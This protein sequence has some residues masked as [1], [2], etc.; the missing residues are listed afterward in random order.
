MSR[1]WIF[2]ANPDRYE[3][4]GAL[5]ELDEIWWRVP[6]YTDEIHIGDRVVVWR[7]G[8]DSGV[9]GLGRVLSEPAERE[10]P[11]VERP[12][13]ES[14]DEGGAATRVR[15]AVV[16]S[17]LVSKDEVAA[18]GDLASHQI[19]T[20]PM[21]TVFS[22]SD[23]QWERIEAAAGVEVPLP[24]VADQVA[25]ELPAPFSWQQ[26]R[27]DTYP[28]P[29]GYD[30][31]LETLA[32][33]LE[34]VAA[35]RPSADRLMGYMRDAFGVTQTSARLSSSFLR[36]VG[37]LDDNAGR[38]EI[39]ALSSR[40]L[41]SRDDELV[42]AQLHARVR[43]IG[44]MVAAADIPRT[45][46]ELL[47]VATE[48]FG[49]TW[50]TKAQISRRR[51]WLQSAKMLEVD[52]ENRLVATEN[53]RQLVSRLKLQ[54]PD[55]VEPATRDLSDAAADSENIAKEP[56]SGAADEELEELVARIHLTSIASGTPDDFEYAIRDVF[57]FLGFR[58][59]QLGG[60]GKT[61]VVADADLGRDHSYRVIIDGK[62][63]GNGT[64]SDHQIDWDTIDDHRRLHDA[65]HAVIAAPKFS[66]ARTVE[67]AAS[68]T[69]ALLSASDL[70]ALCRQHALTP[71]GLASYRDLFKRGGEADLE[72]LTAVVED[73]ARQLDVAM[74]ALAAI[75]AHVSEVGAMT[76]RD[77][78]LV[79][80]GD[81]DLDADEN[82]ITDALVALASPFV[83][84][85]A[86]E[87]GAYRPTGPR[88]TSARRLRLLAARLLAD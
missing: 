2:Q 56:G 6:Q 15:L 26:R 45:A 71:I 49:L 53:G 24:V 64:V 86:G 83:G 74:S 65:D 54:E 3:I 77:L 67:R 31:Y 76:A 52:E 75:E 72:S 41:A 78:F 47:K 34:H 30:G 69:V 55:V 88:D 14:E 38:I 81:T 79:M 82:E 9:V 35:Q 62:T 70:E 68:H 42:I 84:L 32:S 10:F 63:A 20:A 12:F 29:G 39:S 22:V 27:K 46:D 50:T 36:R 59:E 21:G 87:E 43:F 58:A 23:E 7:S 51:G 80:R 33:I 61:D 13:V 44:E 40:W 5:R 19:I 66:G 73:S 28:L 16:A 25:S 18:M 8:S 1:C 60:S 57:S 11:E 48:R 17:A 4:D 85:L 37:Y